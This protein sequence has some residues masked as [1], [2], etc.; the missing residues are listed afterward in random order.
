MV[1][2]SD[3]AIP[4]KSNRTAIGNPSQ[5]IEVDSNGVDVIQNRQLIGDAF[6]NYTGVQKRHHVRHGGY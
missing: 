6:P 1:Q 4:N 3:F 2:T 5:I